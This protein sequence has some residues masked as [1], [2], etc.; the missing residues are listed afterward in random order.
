MPSETGVADQ[1]SEVPLL[2][3]FTMHG[4]RYGNPLRVFDDWVHGKSNTYDWGLL[5][6]S[7]TGTWKVRWASSGQELVK[8]AVPV[9][10]EQRFIASFY[11]SRSNDCLHLVPKQAMTNPP[12]RVIRRCAGPRRRRT[13]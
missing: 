12:L 6:S 8:K 1:A 5:S 9:L 3:F 13:T 10:L 11:S 4:E 7:V 2:P